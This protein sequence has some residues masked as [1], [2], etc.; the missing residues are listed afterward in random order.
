[1]F[2]LLRK[3]KLFGK[4]SK[5]KFFAEEIHYLGHIVSADGTRMDLDKVDAI[6]RW[7]T[8]KN[9]EELQIFLGM[10]GFYPQYVKD[11]AKIAVPLTDELKTKDKTIRWGESQQKSFDKI[12][13]AIAAAP[14]LSIVDPNKPFVFDASGAIESRNFIAKGTPCCI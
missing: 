5:C 8:P 2:E 10:S 14:I 11:Y 3:N 6:I 13:V 4:E 1:M 9:L 12:K 7:P